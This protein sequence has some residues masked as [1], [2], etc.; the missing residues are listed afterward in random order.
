MRS[1]LFSFLTLIIFSSNNLFPQKLS[2]YKEDLKFTLDTNSFVVDGLYYFSNSDSVKISQFIFYPFPTDQTLGDID[3]AIVYDSTFKKRIEFS[4]S[5]DNK[6][7]S[8]PLTME[9]YGFR[10]IRIYYRQNLK[11]NMAKYI[12]ETTKNWGKPLEIANYTLTV[13]EN[14]KID[15]L[16]YA[17]DSSKIIDKKN[18]YFWSKKNFLPQKDFLIYFRK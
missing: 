13:P 4:R 18:I 11:G 8:F 3:S 2:F 1:L 15:S 6:G 12:L 7:I 10:R 5:K 9:G 16:S 14:I 17:A